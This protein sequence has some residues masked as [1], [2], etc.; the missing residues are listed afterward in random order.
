MLRSSLGRDADFV[1]V[2]GVGAATLDDLWLVDDF[3]SEE[4]V[5]QALGHSRMGGGPVATSL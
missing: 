4:G 5:H 2:V 1:Q 3:R